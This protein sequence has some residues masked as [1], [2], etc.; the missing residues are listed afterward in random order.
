M[1]K[2]LLILTLL[3][4]ANTIEATVPIRVLETTQQ[5]GTTHR[6][7]AYI[8]ISA[9]YLPSISSLAVL[10]HTDCGTVNV[11]ITNESNGGSENFN[12][13][14]AAGSYFLPVQN[15]CGDYVVY[16]TLSSGVTYYGEFEVE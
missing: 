9:D 3:C 8:P 7:P 13:N 6:M 12:F 5:T 10:F 14:A 4:V 16:F 1:K 11:T 2:F 15:G